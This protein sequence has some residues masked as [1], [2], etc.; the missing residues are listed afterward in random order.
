MPLPQPRDYAVANM[1]NVLDSGF[2]DPAHPQY[3]E[4]PA[5]AQHQQL[6]ARLDLEV[7]IPCTVP[8]KSDTVAKI[9]TFDI[10]GTIPNDF[11]HR[12]CA[13]M[14]KTRDAAELGWKS[15][16]AKKKEAPKA[17]REA[18]DVTHAWNAH[19]GLVKSTRR[20]KP[21]YMEIVDMSAA[22]KL[23]VPKPVQT[24]GFTGRVHGMGAG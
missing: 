17:L 3:G 13:T 21:V 22:K 24:R 10:K 20:T 2:F 4:P 18:N 11:L 14:G 5:L 8:G 1:N 6:A 23:H 16:D 19:E 9:L 7:H 15:C 12:V